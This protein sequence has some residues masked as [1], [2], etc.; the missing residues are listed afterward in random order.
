M[1]LFCFSSSCVPDDDN[2]PGLT[3][4]DCPFS[5][6]SKITFNFHV[7]RE[8]AFI[9]TGENSSHRLDLL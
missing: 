2:F 1:F 3:I 5:V 8:V 9:I 4:F 7:I 6:L